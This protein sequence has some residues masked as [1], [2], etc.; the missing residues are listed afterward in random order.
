MSTSAVADGFVW[1]PYVSISYEKTRVI[2][3]TRVIFIIAIITTIIAINIIIIIIIIINSLQTWWL[4]MAARLAT[5][6]AA[7]AGST[8]SCY[9]ARRI[10]I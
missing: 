1:F 3:V 9:L 8:G 10:I 5:A 4:E 7:I 2:G 6:T